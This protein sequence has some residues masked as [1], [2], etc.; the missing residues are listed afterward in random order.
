MEWVTAILGSLFKSVVD[1]IGLWIERDRAE[2]A[3]WNAATSKAQL[4]SIKQIAAENALLEQ[5]GQ[6]K[7]LVTK[8]PGDWLKPVARVLVFLGVLQLSGCICASRTTY[9]EGARPYLPAPERQELPEGPEVWSPRE[10]ALVER[11]ETLE[12]LIQTYN[13]QAKDHNRTHGYE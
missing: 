6:P 1:Y 7:P 4:E 2:A 11:I 13:D 9:V 8:T 10:E 3:R 12:R 5:A